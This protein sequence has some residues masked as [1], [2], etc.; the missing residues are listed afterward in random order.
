M[1]ICD[2]FLEKLL[3]CFPSRL[4]WTLHLGQ[5]EVCHDET[6]ETSSSPDVTALSTKV[7]LVGVEHVTRKENAGNVDDIVSTSSNTGCQGP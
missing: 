1:I 2:L 4:L 6:E 7:G 5:E 3:S